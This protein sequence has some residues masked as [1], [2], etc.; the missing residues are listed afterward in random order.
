MFWEKKFFAPGFP[1]SV[2]R[3]LS[4]C[5]LDLKDGVLK[6]FGQRRKSPCVVF[7]YIHERK[8]RRERRLFMYHTKII[9]LRVR[10]EDHNFMTEYAEK[11]DTTIS[12][13]LRAYIHS[14]REENVHE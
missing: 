13:I 11:E 14:L 7:L 3:S 6:K 4:K 9:T 2:A 10:E 8:A 5:A 1:S 12:A